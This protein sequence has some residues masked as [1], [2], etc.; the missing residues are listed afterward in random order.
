MNTVNFTCKVSTNC[1]ELP[2]NLKID[3]NNTVV[4]DDQIINDVNISFDFDDGVEVE[5]VVKFIVHGKTDL[6]TQLSNTNE[7]IKSSEI[8]ITQ[9]S[10]DGFSLTPYIMANPLLYIHSNNGYTDQ[11]HSEFFDTAG[12]NGEI[13]LKFTSP[14]YLWLLDNM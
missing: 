4:F 13:I 5:H 2:I 8:T 1:P 10:L 6:H 3:H 7:I 14:I 12:C 9:I 11:I